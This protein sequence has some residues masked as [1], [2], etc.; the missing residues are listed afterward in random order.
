MNVSIIINNFHTYNSILIKY[1]MQGIENFLLS[2]K[3][4]HLFKQIKDIKSGGI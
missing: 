2:L 1:I 4:I 3:Y